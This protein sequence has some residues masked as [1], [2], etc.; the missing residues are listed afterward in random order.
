MHSATEV[1]A[2][3]AG[4]TVLVTGATGFTGA[5]L[6]RKLCEHGARVRAIARPSSNLG[7]LQG[8]PI[9]WHMGDVFDPAAVDKAAA[10]VKYIFHVAA[11]YRQAGLADDAYRQVH[12]ESTRRLAES[13][14]KNPGFKR[15]IHVSTGGAHGHIERPPA[16]ENYPFAPGD[17]YQ[18]TKA[19][20]EIWI[21]DFAR[22]SGLP[23]TVIRP[24]AIYGP[25]DR[26]LLKIFKMAAWQVCLL[27]GRARGQLYHMIHVDDLTEA[28]M[29]AA[30]HP[31]ALG[32]VFICGDPAALA[33]ADILE[34]IGAEYG[35]KVR[36]LS[37][38][39]W[40]LFFAAR[41]CEAVCRPLGIAPPIYRRR[42][43]FFT[44]DRS[45]NTNKLRERL[46]YV[47]RRSTEQ[48]LRE[49]ARWYL[50]QGWVKVRR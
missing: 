20:A 15:F 44:K 27:P 49:T 37:I 21:R 11:A 47:C 25:G 12:I 24:A 22:N 48:G 45:F 39:S 33:L 16:D 14:M 8:L 3:M 4:E 50:E 32:E 26:R 34:I 23:V 36:I 13:A 10:G 42:V 41:V 30:V 19:E 17:I 9:E 7:P 46:G 40:P 31:A 38:P 2:N 1:R 35:R 5:V 28:L 6:A 43:A 29:L 18:D